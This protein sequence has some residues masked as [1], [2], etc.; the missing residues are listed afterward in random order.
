MKKLFALLAAQRE[1]T[2]DL[3]L[4]VLRLSIGGLMLW[5]HG[6]EKI[7]GYEKF[8]GFVAD[9]GLPRPEVL[10]PLAA[11]AEVVGAAL[12]ALGLLT[13]VGALAVAGTMAVAAF[14][15]QRDD[16]LAKQEM[17]LL[18]LAAATCVLLAGPGR[19]SLDRALFAK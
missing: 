14:Y 2:T 15:I 13:R 16:G 5:Q 1:T 9:S 17:A 6:L 11:G 4:L 8:A 10:A 7:K 3:G 18:Y 12:F 19:F